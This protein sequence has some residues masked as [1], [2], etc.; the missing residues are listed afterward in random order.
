MLCVVCVIFSFLFLR[1]NNIIFMDISHLLICSSTDVV[2]LLLFF[3]VVN[4]VVVKM[5]VPISV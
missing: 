2:R 4:N 1:L 3:A 5:G